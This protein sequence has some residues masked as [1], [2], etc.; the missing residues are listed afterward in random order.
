[1]THTQNLSVLSSLFLLAVTAMLVFSP[2]TLLS[3]ESSE[4]F[5]NDDIE[6]VEGEDKTIYEYRQNGRLMMVK[7]IPKW[8]KPY[9]M[10]PADGSP[11]YSDLELRE[12]LYPQW[13]IIE[14]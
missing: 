3:S 13:V 5:R 10:V 12:N 8:G 2:T 11:H 1:M 4:D 7:I 6:I 9:Y 14:W